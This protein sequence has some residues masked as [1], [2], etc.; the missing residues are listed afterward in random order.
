M[1]KRLLRSILAIRTLSAFT[2]ARRRR[3]RRRHSFDKL[4]HVKLVCQCGCGQILMECN[5]VGCAGLLP[6]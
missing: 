1:P 5:H 3:K 6:S 4:G 2:H